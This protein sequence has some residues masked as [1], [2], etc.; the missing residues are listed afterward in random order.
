MSECTHRQIQ[1]WKTLDDE[2]L[3]FWSC[4]DCGHRFEPL[5]AQPMAL[6]NDDLMKL[7]DKHHGYGTMWVEFARALEAAHGIRVNK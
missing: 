1:A 6:S 2:P 4:V 7:I 3:D 5:S